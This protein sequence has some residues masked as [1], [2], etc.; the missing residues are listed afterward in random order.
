MNCKPG[1]LAVIVFALTG[2]SL[3]ILVEVLHRWEGGSHNGQRFAND[4]P[5]WVVKSLGRNLVSV[6]SRGRRHEHS[7]RPVADVCLRP[8]RDQP[9]NEQFVVEARKSLPRPATAKGDTI[10]ARGEVHS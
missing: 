1:D 6:D 10:D 5:A 9:D 3:G 4:A 7:S 2:E 8:I